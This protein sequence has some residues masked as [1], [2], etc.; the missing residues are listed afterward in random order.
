LKPLLLAQHGLSLTTKAGTIVLRNRIIDR[1]EAWTPREFPYD[2]V[3]VEATGGYVTWEALRWLASNGVSVTLLQFNGKPAFVALPDAPVHA[4]DRIAQLRAHSDPERRLQVAR[5]FV[6]AKVRASVRAVPEC[7][8]AAVAPRITTLDGLVLY[9]GR[10]AEAYWRGRGVVRDYPNARDP[11]NA[12]LDYAYGL[13]ESRA[14]LTIHRLS[15]EPSVG[16]LH[17]PRETKSAFVYDV[18][19]P[20][21][22]EA[23]DVALAL[24]P[25]LAS[26][27]FFRFF[28]H[29]LRLRAPAALRLVAA[30][31]ARMNAGVEKA[32]LRETARLARY[33]ATVRFGLDERWG[34]IQ[35]SDGA[36]LGGP[37][38]AALHPPKRPMRGTISVAVRAR[39]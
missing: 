39:T 25:K 3:I 22:T 33:F 11:T 29:G 2:S 36:S 32:M 4:L 28:G 37:V 38:R 16:F 20:W 9:E 17:Q 21:R 5:A 15:L 1:R 18:M 19:E 7:A 30:F 34:R 26:S 31:S 27:D 13:L 12:V 24:V 23:D 8:W 6:E 35:A 14:R 10:V